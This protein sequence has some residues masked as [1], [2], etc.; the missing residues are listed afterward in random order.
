M[1]L[2]AFIGHGKTKGKTN[3]LFEDPRYLSVAID[4]SA[5]DMAANNGHT[6]FLTLAYMLSFMF[7]ISCFAP[8]L[9]LNNRRNG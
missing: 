2:Q 5:W 4:G 7:F 1:R 6:H 8:I 3:G 9:S